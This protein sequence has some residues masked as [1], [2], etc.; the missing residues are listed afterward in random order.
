MAD[1]KG[2][3]EMVEERLREE[4]KGRIRDVEEFERR[5]K[6][7]DAAVEEAIRLHV[8]LLKLSPFTKRWWTSELAEKKK[9]ME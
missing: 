9:E 4:G 2:V 7:L 8:P 6:V 5:L 1:W 3:R